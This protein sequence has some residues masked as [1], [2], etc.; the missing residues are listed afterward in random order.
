[1][2]TKKL[3]ALLTAVEVS[4]SRT[5]GS[6]RW[7]AGVSRTPLRPRSRTVKPIS[8]S[9]LFIMWVNPDCV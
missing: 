7:P 8:F 5:R 1:M 9:R 2:D 6:I 3:E 4:Q